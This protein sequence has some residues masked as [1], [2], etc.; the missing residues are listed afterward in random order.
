MTRTDI[1]RPSAI[2]PDD[3]TFVGFECLPGQNED[4][5]GWAQAQQ[6]ERECIQAHMA[7]TG[8]TYSQ[9]EHGGNCHVCGSVNAIYTALFYHEKTNSYIRVGQDC[10]RKIELG[11]TGDWNA[12]IAR[13]KNHMEARAG[14]RKAE[15]QLTEWGLERCWAIYTECVIEC[16]DPVR[17]IGPVAIVCDIVGKLVRYGSISDKQVDFLRKLLDQIDRKDEIAAERQAEYETAE[18]APKGRVELTGT[19]VGLKSVEGWG[20]DQTVMKMIVKAEAGW[21]VFV[22]VPDALFDGEELKGRTITMRVTVEPSDDDPKFAWGK[23]PH[24]IKEK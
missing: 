19:I 10:A 6:A 15:A 1:H 20:Y 4:P 11:G 13:V 2:E 22:T 5:M 8:G 7:H 17:G 3:Y 18:P 21:K 23:R 12:F 9:H 14:K 16:S 24:I